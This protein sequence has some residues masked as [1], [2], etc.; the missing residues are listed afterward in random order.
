M[1]LLLRVLARCVSCHSRVPVGEGRSF[2][3]AGGGNGGEQLPARAF[4]LAPLAMAP[5]SRGLE[6]VTA[7][8]ELALEP[9]SKS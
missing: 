4:S 9:A 3:L 8:L 2:V 7:R 6:P 5:L 1:F